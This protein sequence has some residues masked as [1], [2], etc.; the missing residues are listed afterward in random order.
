MTSNIPEIG[1]LPTSWRRDLDLFLAERAQGMNAYM[2]SRNRLASV[3]RLAMLSDAELA[4]LGLA[5]EDIPAFVFED[6]L[7]G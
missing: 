5:R 2:L 3:A 1:F 4:E 7:P 6:I